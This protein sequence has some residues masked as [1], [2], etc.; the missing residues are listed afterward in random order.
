MLL[1]FTISQTVLEGM[2]VMRT[3]FV[4]LNHARITGIVRVT[5]VVLIVNANLSN[6]GRIIPKIDNKYSHVNYIIITKC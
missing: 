4:L 1:C 3:I 6:A 5:N 2:Y